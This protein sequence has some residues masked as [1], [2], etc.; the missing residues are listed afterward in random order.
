M[1]IDAAIN[2]HDIQMS[3]ASQYPD[4]TMSCRKFRDISMPSEK[5]KIDAHHLQ[6]MARIR[7][8]ILQLTL[9]ALSPN[10]NKP[11]SINAAASSSA[12]PRLSQRLIRRWSPIVC[13]PLR[14]YL[15][16]P[17][18]VSGVRLLRSPIK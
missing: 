3:I 4:L 8:T 12:S 1:F 18:T 17:R 11:S 9:E 6:G 10:R 13:N 16:M 14:V 2:L 7:D 15:G 5:K